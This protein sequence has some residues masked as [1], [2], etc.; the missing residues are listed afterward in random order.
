V[1]HPGENTICLDLGNKAVSAEN[2]IENRVR[3]PALPVEK[4][5]GQSEEHLVLEVADRSAFPIGAK[6][7]GVPYHVCPSVAL[8][9]RAVVVRDGECTE[10]EWEIEARDRR[11]IV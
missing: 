6:I 7:I 2:P 4:F 5:I 11:L 3:F 10:E 1:S 9:Q 8:Y